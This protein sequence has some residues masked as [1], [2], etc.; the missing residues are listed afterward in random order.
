MLVVVVAPLVYSLLAPE[1]WLQSLIFPKKV[2]AQARK[3][4][5]GKLLFSPGNNCQ[6]MNGSVRH[7][8]FSGSLIKLHLI[9]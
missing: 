4:S 7:S 9:R 2:I 6:R 1:K 8:N 3:N 5:V